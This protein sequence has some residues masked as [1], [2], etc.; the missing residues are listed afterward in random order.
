MQTQ[1]DECGLKSTCKRLR[2]HQWAEWWVN[3]D[4]EP[5]Y[6]GTKGVI[7]GERLGGRKCRIWPQRGKPTN[8]SIFRNYN[9]RRVVIPNDM[10]QARAL[11]LGCSGR[12]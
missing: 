3:L 1:E 6:G 12:S 10:K 9:S 5:L 4:R 11:C 7:D 2:D 8:G